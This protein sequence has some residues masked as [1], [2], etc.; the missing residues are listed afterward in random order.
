M[1][2]GFAVIGIPIY[3]WLRFE[4]QFGVGALVAL[5]HDVIADARAS[6]R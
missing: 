4:W 2:L 1:A 3:I 6:S 5:I